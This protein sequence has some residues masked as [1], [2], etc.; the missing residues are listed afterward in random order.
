MN[1]DMPNPVTLSS[2]RHRTPSPVEACEGLSPVALVLEGMRKQ[3][4][5]LVQS[6]RQ[7][8]YCHRGTSI[9][10][11]KSKQLTN[12]QR[13]FRATLTSLTRIVERAGLDLDLPRLNQHMTGVTSATRLPRQTTRDHLNAVPRLQSSCRRPGLCEA[14]S[15]RELQV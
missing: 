13:S 15:V 5:S 1:V 2:D 9:Y 8:L 10:A 11:T 4:M 7:Y 3:R 6:L 12:P 14:E